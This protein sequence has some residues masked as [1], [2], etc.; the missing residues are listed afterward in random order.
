MT[1]D[2]K[3]PYVDAGIRWHILDPVGTAGGIGFRIEWEYSHVLFNKS[4]KPFPTKDFGNA[5]QDVSLPG[6]GY[7][8]L[9]FGVIIALALR[10]K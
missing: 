4:V 1:A 5:T 10:A 2:S 8:K 3:C 7:F 6:G 9:S